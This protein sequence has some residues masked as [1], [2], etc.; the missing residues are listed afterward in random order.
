MLAGIASLAIIN[1]SSLKDEKIEFSVVITTELGQFIKMTP[2]DKSTIP[3]DGVGT[4]EYR[5]FIEGERISVSLTVMHDVVAHIFEF[6]PVI[7]FG[8]RG[9]VRLYAETIDTN[10]KRLK[11]DL[12]LRVE[13][14]SLNEPAQKKPRINKRTRPVLNGARTVAIIEHHRTESVKKVNAREKWGAKVK[15]FFQCIFQNE[16]RRYAFIC[17]WTERMS[18]NR[19]PCENIATLIQN[20]MNYERNFALTGKPGRWSVYFFGPGAW[21]LPASQFTEE[22]QAFFTQM[23]EHKD[24]LFETCSELVSDQVHLRQMYLDD[25]LGDIICKRQLVQDLA[26]LLIDAAL[27]RGRPGLLLILI[28]AV[29]NAI[30]KTRRPDRFL[31]YL[32]RA[33]QH[34]N[35][36]ETVSQLGMFVKIGD[37]VPEYEYMP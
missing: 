11:Y 23:Y 6:T 5:C 1:K 30:S 10:V 28:S 26:I 19:T 35:V 4:L 27:H 16:E 37:Q 33:L 17:K 29:C 36:E 18:V 8:Q 9:W 20:F 34:V 25:L 13:D 14:E 21:M 32:F 12:P 24:D 31:I 7:T 2:L 3:W 15:E 22:E